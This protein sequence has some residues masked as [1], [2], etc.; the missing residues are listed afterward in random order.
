MEQLVINLP[1]N[2]RLIHRQIVK[3]MNFAMDLTNQEQLVLAKLIEYNINYAALDPLKRAKFIL[4]TSIKKEMCDSLK[5]KSTAFSQILHRLKKKK[6]FNN[7]ILDDDGVLKERVII[8]PDNEGVT[9]N[10]SFRNDLRSNAKK[11]VKESPQKDFIPEVSTDE[12]EETET[13]GLTDYVD[14]TDGVDFE[15]GGIR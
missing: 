5:M 14:P 2:E 8:V 3:F 7:N 10:I 9:I 4:S 1:Y 12:Q 11:E 13:V 6:F 15:I